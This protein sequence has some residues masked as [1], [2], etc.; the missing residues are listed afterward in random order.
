[1]FIG[2][3]IVAANEPRIVAVTDEIISARLADGRAISVP[4]AWSWRLADATPEQRGHFEIIGGG[5]EVHWPD[6]DEDISAVGMLQGVPAR[7]PK[8]SG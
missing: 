4:P 5:E 6:V 1:M 7:R 8:R 2:M 3:N